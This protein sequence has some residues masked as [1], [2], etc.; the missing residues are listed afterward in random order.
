[1]AVRTVKK[2]L[3]DNIEMLKKDFGIIYDYSKKTFTYKKIEEIEFLEEKEITEELLSEYKGKIIN[4]DKKERIIYDIVKDKPDGTQW[5]IKT[6]KNDIVLKYFL[7]DLLFLL[8]RITT[9]NTKT[10]QGLFALE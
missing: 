8:N 2:N 6:E 10:L 9:E 7:D 1:M 5:R 3:K 4:Y